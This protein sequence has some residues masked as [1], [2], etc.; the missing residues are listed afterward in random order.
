M[1]EILALYSPT[2]GETAEG[3]QADDRQFSTDLEQAITILE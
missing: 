3:L 2:K 1:S